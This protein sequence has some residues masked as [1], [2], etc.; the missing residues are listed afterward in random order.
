MDMMTARVEDS[1]KLI[2]IMLY[3]FWY[4]F[5]PK[6]TETYIPIPVRYP[7]NTASMAWINCAV[8]AVAANA[9]L[10]MNLPIIME[11]TRLYD[12]VRIADKI[13]GMA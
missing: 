2:L 8:T 1:R 5:L 7:Q 10:P 12:C 13:S 9:S 6:S 4:S 3:I 11:F